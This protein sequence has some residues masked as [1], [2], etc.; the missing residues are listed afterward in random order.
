MFV[1]FVSGFSLALMG[2]AVFDEIVRRFDGTIW[3]GCRF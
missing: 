3:L 1:I 2:L